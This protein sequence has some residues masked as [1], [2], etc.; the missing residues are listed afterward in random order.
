[1]TAAVGDTRLAETG[2]RPRWAGLLVRP[3][4]I[5]AGLLMLW[6]WASGRPLDSIEARNVNGA[7]IGSQVLEHVE[8]TLICTALTLVVAVPLGIAV[9]LEFVGPLAVAVLGS[10]R[11]LDF[12]WV[13]LA[14]AG[15]VLLTTGGEGAHGGGSV[16]AVGVL[17]ALAA[18]GFWAAYILLA[19]RVGRVFPGASGLAFALA[20]GAVAVLPIGI[21]AAGTNL[22][23]PSVLARGL[24][25][26][27]LS[28]AVPYSLE[29]FA[30]RRMRA[31]VFGVLM[32]LEPAVAALAGFVAL[33]QVLR[34]AEL[35]GIAMVV[36][37]SG[38]AALLSHR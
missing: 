14:A 7:V 16:D 17:W 9:T 20:I 10:R 36:V 15:V 35:L 34:P 31:S 37:A 28:S 26:A 18:G 8:L 13:L 27:V 23:D 38:G 4:L 11:P 1:V 25:V 24:A 12:V 29:L 5:G 33:G 3:V 30:L 2:E 21:A 6:L 19:Q 22:L 32:S